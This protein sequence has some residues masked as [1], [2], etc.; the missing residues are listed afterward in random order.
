[1]YYVY[2]LKSLK[3]SSKYIGTT[4]DLK[5]RLQEHNDFE[6]VS[7]KSKAPYWIAWYCAFIEKTQAYDFEKYLKSS[8]GYAFTKKHL[9]A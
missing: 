1:M 4:T 7:N 2:I 6:T 9:T 8:S 5:N 3:D